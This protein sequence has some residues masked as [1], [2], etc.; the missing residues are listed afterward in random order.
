MT[1]AMSAKGC[2]D[3]ADLEFNFRASIHLTVRGEQSGK[4]HEI[5]EILHTNGG[6]DLFYFNQSGIMA[7]QSTRE[8][9]EGWG[10]NFGG[11]T[12]RI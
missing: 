9:G 5:P 11:Y 3:I 10:L 4:Y 7:I 2:I 6:N 12:L 8:G 1:H